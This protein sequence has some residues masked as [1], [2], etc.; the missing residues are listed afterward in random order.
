MLLGEKWC[1]I[2]FGFEGLRIDRIR[3][4]WHDFSGGS[5][6]RSRFN[7]SVIM[8]RSSLRDNTK[9]AV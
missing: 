2:L 5:L 6:L 3:V 9:N 1:W 7:F 8:Q 4:T